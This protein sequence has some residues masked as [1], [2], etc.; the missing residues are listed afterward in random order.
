[1]LKFAMSSSKSTHIIVDK[2]CFSVSEGH[3]TMSLSSRCRSPY[4][5][6]IQKFIV[7]RELKNYMIP[8]FLSSKL[9]YNLSVFSWV[10]SFG[11]SFWQFPEVK[12]F[13]SA[14]CSFPLS[15][16]CIVQNLGYDKNSNVPL[17]SCQGIRAPSNLLS[18]SHRNQNP[19]LWYPTQ[20]SEPGMG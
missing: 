14:V 15:V 8:S 16:A 13:T 7:A 5:R 10:Y 11:Q 1:M 20:D 17:I 9:A 3:I 2:N 4:S 6:L 19:L 18:Q 12:Q